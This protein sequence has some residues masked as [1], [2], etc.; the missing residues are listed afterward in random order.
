MLGPPDTDYTYSG[1]QDEEFDDEPVKELVKQEMWESY[2]LFYFSNEGQF[3]MD[4]TDHLRSKLSLL[5][6]K[7]TDFDLKFTELR[8]FK[9]DKEIKG[10]EENL[11]ERIR[12]LQDMVL[13]SGLKSIFG[14]IAQFVKLP[15]SPYP[16]AEDCMGLTG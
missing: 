7:V 13:S 5:Q 11:N 12:V 15:I 10:E 8:V 4:F 9:G 14:D 2:R 1:E 16:I 6:A 3:K